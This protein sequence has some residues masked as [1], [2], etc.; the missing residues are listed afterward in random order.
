[1]AIMKQIAWLMVSFAGGLLIGWLVLGQLPEPS[2][3]QRIILD[4]H[5]QAYCHPDRTNIQ[6]A[7]VEAAIFSRLTGSGGLGERA[8]AEFSIARVQG[9][10]T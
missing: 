5:L 9:A 8:L 2:L 3:A 7:A 6:K 4:G 10:C 1:M